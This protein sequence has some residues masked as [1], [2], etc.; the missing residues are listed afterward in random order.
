MGVFRKI[1]ICAICVLFISCLECSLAYIGL[2]Q[3]QKNVKIVNHIGVVRGKS[4]RLS[5][6]EL[7][8]LPHDNI[9]QQL[10]VILEALTLGENSELDIATS[11]NTD[12]WEPLQKLNRDWQDLKLLIREYRADRDSRGQLLKAS[13]KFW[14]TCNET[15]FSAQEYSQK[16]VRRIILFGA[17]G[18]CINI[19]LLLV[20]YN[21]NEGV[22]KVVQ[23][24]LKSVA[25]Y[26]SQ[27]QVTVEKQ[28]RGLE[29]QARSV[30]R[31]TTAIEQLRASSH[32]ASNYSEESAKRSTQ[33]LAFTDG[34]TQSVGQTQTCVVELKEQVSCIAD[35]IEELSRQTDRIG[36]VSTLVQDIANQTNV[37]ALNANIEASRA[38]EIGR[39][40]G[41]VAR[42]IRQLSAQSQQSAET[43]KTIVSDIQNAI[44]ATANLI[45]S[46][47]QA[48][49]DGE[50]SVRET[51][52]TFAQ[53]QDAVSEITQSAREMAGN[54]QQQLEAIQQIA[55]VMN[56]LN[57][58]ASDTVV[59]I[60][61]A[62]VET[63]K[64]RE[65][66]Q[67]LRASI[68]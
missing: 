65:I 21:M 62:Q 61:H 13:E 10:D 43:I 27:I 23:K 3:T 33:V 49:R 24:T 2:V 51:A 15:A 26:L 6:L 54:A 16:Q 67:N 17:I 28:E 37:L 38:G 57:L 31:T 36:R 63:Q 41:V 5:K 9:I 46:G 56:E 48:A 19:I 44:Q 52:T 25:N 39:E 64:V 14:D 68:E 34:G 50:D 42:E 11:P 8:N 20:F 29:A 30:S 60:R 66:L 40:F 22:A 35:N 12:Y 18:L 58:G 53:V 32:Q 7:M 45:R 47:T 1:R 4:Q 55:L 59:G